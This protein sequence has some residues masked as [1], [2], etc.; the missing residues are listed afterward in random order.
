MIERPVNELEA[1]SARTLAHYD[2]VAEAFE[3]GTRTHDVTQNYA[4]L[5]S[6]RSKFRPI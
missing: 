4:A 1:F 5:C 3:E 6:T 2:S